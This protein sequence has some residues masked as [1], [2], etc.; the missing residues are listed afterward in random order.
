VSEPFTLLDAGRATAVDATSDGGRVLLD[1]EGLEQAT[2][3]AHRPE[4]LCHGDVCVPVRDPELVGANG[5][6]DLHRF[7]Q[8]L[9]RPLAVDPSQRVA[10]LGAPAG[11]R[12]STLTG[13]EA[14]E[15]ALPD[16][17]GRIHRLSDYHGRKVLLAA[18]AS[19]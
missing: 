6:I 3:W 19:W 11:E 16:L 5:T 15:F 13:G 9:R 4:G 2:G 12:E 18:Y 8:A 17:D 7:A 14:P 1:P 10:A